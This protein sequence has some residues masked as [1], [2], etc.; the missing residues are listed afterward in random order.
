V[1]SFCRVSWQ[2]A[3]ILIGL[4]FSL[5]PTLLSGQMNKWILSPSLV[6]FNSQTA[7]PLTWLSPPTN[8]TVENTAFDASGSPMFYI[9]NKTV[10]LPSG[11]VAGTLPSVTG[12]M[13][14]GGAY[15]G[16]MYEIAIVPVPGTCN[17]FHI[18]WCAQK[19]I[20]G[21]ALCTSLIT[22][23][24]NG[25][26]T[27]GAG[28]LLDEGPGASSALAVSKST[29]FGSRNLYWVGGLRGVVSFQITA[30]GIS[31]GTVWFAYNVNNN[32]L[33]YEGIEAEVDEAIGKVIWVDRSG[34]VFYYNLQNP[35]LEPTYFTNIGQAWGIEFDGP[36]TG[37]YVSTTGTKTLSS[38]IYH[39]ANFFSQFIPTLVSSSLDYEKTFIE[40]AKDGQFYAVDKNGK[41]GKFTGNGPV[42]AAFNGLSVFSSGSVFA[43]GN[44]YKL[45]DQIDGEDYDYFFGVSSYDIT[46]TTINGT[47]LA[48][49]VPPPPPAFYNCNAL[50]IATTWTGQSA[51]WTIQIYSVDPSTGNQLFGAPY[52]NFST[53][54]IGNVPT[55]VDLRTLGGSSDLFANYLGQT[56]A[57]RITGVNLCGNSTDFLLCYFRV[58]GPPASTTINLQVNPGN[59]IPCLASH[60]ISTPCLTSIY[61]ASLNM[62]SSTG[63]IT[64]YSLKI[65]RVNCS[66]GNNETLVFDNSANPVP[67][68]GA[69]QLTAIGLNDLVINGSTG[70][71]VDKCCLCYRIEATIGNSCGSSTDYSF[72]KFTLP[73]CNCFEG[74]GGSERASPQ[75]NNS[76]RV[77]LEDVWAVPNPAEGE[78][79][80]VASNDHEGMLCHAALIF[81]AVGNVVV[82]LANHNLGDP[83]VIGGLPAGLY[84]YRLHTLQGSVSGQF[85]K[86]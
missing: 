36:Q 68:S 55:P 29:G 54:G 49:H 37:F 33:S 61:S 11:A 15:N 48:E 43:A 13:C 19:G 77:L 35:D 18:F 39:F 26:L 84:Y 25:T 58:L 52:L 34:N 50:T 21:T 2:K 38:G 45:P 82:R 27:I 44:H 72:I 69:N 62:G 53:S 78:I 67:V 70:Y 28:T 24:A 4:I 7:F 51:S 59:G 41:L 57:I 10:Y 12:I 86:Q 16:I 8:Y 3:T 81:D 42:S 17:Q 47:N 46:G 23:N 56:F 5:S 64:Y 31:S 66:S 65:Y 79:R 76:Y 60:N 20:C 80:F 73:N 22:V 32:N 83:I 14:G 40:K 74:G 75:G 71:F 85:I 63:D 6:D 30:G 9:R 1:D